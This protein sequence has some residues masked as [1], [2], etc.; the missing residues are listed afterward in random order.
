M[1]KQKTYEIVQ[2]LSNATHFLQLCDQDV[3][4]YFKRSILT[5]QD[6]LKKHKSHIVRSVQANMIDAVLAYSNIS[7]ENIKLSFIKTRLW[8]MKYSF[9]DWC[10]QEEKYPR[11]DTAKG[12]KEGIENVAS[13]TRNSDN[14]TFCRLQKLLA[15][16]EI[17]T[18]CFFITPKYS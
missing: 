11:K 18:T 12:F 4:R 17:S 3:K 16:G 2:F 8:P 9:L 15:A 7:V 1:C 6:Q 14:H 13:R 5:Y 10:S